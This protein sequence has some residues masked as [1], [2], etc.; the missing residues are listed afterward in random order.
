MSFGIYFPTFFVVL[1]LIGIAF[2]V[3]YF[4]RRRQ[5]QQ[6]E[7]AVIEHQTHPQGQ[8]ANSGNPYPAQ[9]MNNGPG[10]NSDGGIYAYGTAP[11]AGQTSY[12]QPVQTNNY[13]SPYGTGNYGQPVGAN[14]T[15]TNNNV[16]YGAPQ[17]N[18][19]YPPPPQQQQGGV[20]QGTATIGTNQYSGG[21]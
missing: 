6:Q 18:A 13:T 1:V 8:F 5:Q 10:G 19:Y 16:Q 2:A 3:F 17:P 20:Y 7:G 4:I 11:T 9:A 21:V 15:Y 14:P 12:G